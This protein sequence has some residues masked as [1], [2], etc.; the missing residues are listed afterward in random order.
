MSYVGADIKGMNRRIVYNLLLHNDGIS[1]ADIS[2]MTGISAPTVIKIVEYLEQ[3]GCVREIGEGVSPLGRKP[4]ILQFDP[5]FGYAVGI[6]FSGVGIDVGIVDFSG[7]VCY[8]ERFPVVPDFEEVMSDILPQK[9]PA[10][11][12][13]SFI[14]PEK[15]RGICIGLPGVVDHEKKTIGLAPLVGIADEKNFSG[16]ISDLS[17]KFKMPIR[18]ENDANM[19]A[20]GEFKARKSCDDEDLLFITLGKGLGAGLIL[21]GKLRTG[22]RY[23]SGELGY[24]VF[25][26]TYCSAK[27]GAGWLESALQLD[28]LREEQKNET[29]TIDNFASYLALAIVNICVSIDIKTVVLGKFCSG[30]FYQ[31]LVQRINYY[32]Q[33]FSKLNVM[34]VPPVSAEPTV[35]GAAQ[36]VID[37][38]TD[39]MFEA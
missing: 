3:T 4:N 10:S 1:R 36:V 18:F 12:K 16:Y 26:G 2:R 38:E 17:E 21:N 24:M 39:K 20:M 28:C 8:T 31:M 27:N 6:N 32:L 34:C 22:P 29:E 5:S 13:K 35:A 19:A 15:I 11:I 30:D 7:T 25:D 23:F 37:S 9:I 14:P 33:K